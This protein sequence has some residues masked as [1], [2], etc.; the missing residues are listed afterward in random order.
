MPFDRGSSAATLT[1]PGRVIVVAL[2]SGGDVYPLIALG[3]ALRERGH[4]VVMATTEVFA[5]VVNEAGLEHVRI[6]DERSSQSAEDDPNL[7]KFPDGVK[8]LFGRLLDAVPGTY[9]LIAE[10]YEPGRTAVVANFLCFGARLAQEKL[11]VPLATVHYQPVMLRSLNV[12]PGRVIDPRWRPLLRP[13]RR[14]LTYVMDRHVF[15]PVLSPRLNE[16]RAGLGLPAQQ[17]WMQQWIQSPDLVLGLFPEWFAEMQ[18]DW[19]PNTK[20]TGF[21]LADAASQPELAEE[22]ERFLGDGEPPI[23]FTFGTAMAFGKEFFG[24]SVEVCRQLGRR[25]LLLSRYDDQIP[26]DLPATIRRFSYAPLGRLLPRAAALVHHGGVGTMAQALAAGCPQLITPL[27]FDQPDNAARVQALGV[28][29][30]LKPKEY[31][32]AQ[33]AA[34]VRELLESPSIRQRNREIQSRF[35]GEDPIGQACREVEYLLGR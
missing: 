13:L 21:P 24:V 20:L 7:W 10:R 1:A 8:I 3:R 25:G 2:G 27:N 17:R 28:G 19:P 14:L 9:Q 26:P 29:L 22:V 16:F 33:A 23:V 31:K 35:A 12:Q 32:G 30:R 34:T 18:P 5:A 4:E 11:G 6:G 15:D